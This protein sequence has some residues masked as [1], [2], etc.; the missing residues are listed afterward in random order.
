MRRENNNSMSSAKFGAKPASGNDFGNATDSQVLVGST[1][2]SEKAGFKKAGTYDPEAVKEGILNPLKAQ[3]ETIS[4]QTGARAGVEVGDTLQAIIDLIGRD[5]DTGGSVNVGSIFS[6]L[7]E[8]LNKSVAGMPYVYKRPLSIKIVSSSTTVT[9]RGIAFLQRKMSTVTVDG[10]RRT[11][12]SLEKDGYVRELSA[13]ISFQK[14]IT[15]TYGWVI[16]Y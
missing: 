14:N 3:S 13:W 9:G 10:V 12:E 1:F 15:L 5:T 16:L 6:K 4:K 7:N 2:S 11:V 8:I